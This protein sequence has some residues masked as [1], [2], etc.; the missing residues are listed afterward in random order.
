MDSKSIQFSGFTD[1]KSHYAILDALRGIAAIIIVMFHIFETFTNGDHSKQ[2]INHGYLAV[3][4]FFVLSGFV[5]GYAYDD[6]WGKMGLRGFFKRRLIRLHPMIIIG[7]LIGAVTFYFQ[8]SFFFPAIASTPY[9]KLLLVLI[10]GFTLLPVP[11]SLD[12]RGW[13]EMHP[14]DGPAWSLFF[15]YIANILY[16]LFIRKFSNTVLAILVFIAGA[17]LIHLAVTSP[18]GDVIGG[19][20]V[21]PHQFRIG[22]TRLLYPFFAGLLLSR[23]CKPGQIKKAF[24]WSSLILIIILFIPRIGGSQLWMNGIYD[25]LTI[26]FIFPL[27]VFIGASGDVKGKFTSKFG[28]FLGDISFPLYIIHYPFIYLYMAWIARNKAFLN[29][30][31]SFSSPILVIVS[32]GVLVAAMACAYACVKLYDEPVRKWLTRKFMTSKAK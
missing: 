5:I 17:A 24:L 18:N 31:F 30:N 29:G 12:I 10:I 22:L 23:I 9:W 6:R 4:F 32:I 27:I 14:L 28:K 15:E 8:A 7:M 21:E 26:I 1:T 16:A 19:W 25:S 3:D 2:I 11:S 13:Q 20:S